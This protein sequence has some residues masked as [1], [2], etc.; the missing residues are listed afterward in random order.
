[1]FYSVIMLSD[2]NIKREITTCLQQSDEIEKPKL[3]QKTA[4]IKTP[5]F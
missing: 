5:L 1:M 2:E 3:A 4:I